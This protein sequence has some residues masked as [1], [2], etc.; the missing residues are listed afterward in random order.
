MQIEEFRQILGFSCNYVVA[1]GKYIHVVDN[2]ISVRYFRVVGASYCVSYNGRVACKVIYN[3]A[4]LNLESIE[5]TNMMDITMNHVFRE[6][7][8]TLCGHINLPIFHEI[9]HSIFIVGRDTRITN[10][11]VL[12]VD[13][14]CNW[15]LT[16]NNCGVINPL[17]IHNPNTFILTDSGTYLC[18]ECAGL[19]SASLIRDGICSCADC[20]AARERIASSSSSRHVSVPLRIDR[21]GLE[22]AFTL[23]MNPRPR[24]NDTN[25][26]CRR[27]YNYVPNEYKIHRCAEETKEPIFGIELEFESENDSF[28]DMERLMDENV[29]TFGTLFYFKADGSLNTS[30]SIEIVS[31]PMTLT[32]F[33]TVDW[34]ELFAIVSKYNYIATQACGLHVHIDKSYLSTKQVSKIAYWLHQNAEC[35]RIYADRTREQ[36][37]RYANILSMNGFTLEGRHSYERDYQCRNKYCAINCKQYTVEFRFMGGTDRCYT[38]IERIMFIIELVES[39]KRRRANNYIDKTVGDV[40]EGVHKRVKER[41]NAKVT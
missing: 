13:D 4:T 19:G 17:H 20:V 32:Y 37:Q 31:H 38:F 7:I 11:T 34:T 14:S 18:E 40:I 26:K 9:M 15:H 36:L 23:T 6:F 2:H 27:D 10:K 21:T 35:V 28:N 5:F 39:G 25:L 33:N 3:P 1:Q 22:S 12:C 29:D 24:R 8:I 16:C 30:A 41:N